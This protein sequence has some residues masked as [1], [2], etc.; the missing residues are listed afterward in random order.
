MFI[1][2]ITKYSWRGV[3]CVVLHTSHLY[4]AIQSPGTNDGG[5]IILFEL[6]Q[7]QQQ[8]HNVRTGFQTRV[9]D[10]QNNI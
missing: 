4:N 8:L 5:N 1:Y 2:V 10:N 9:R 6:Q 3:W 7:M